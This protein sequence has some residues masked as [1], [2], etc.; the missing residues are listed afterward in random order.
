MKSIFISKSLSN[1][2]SKLICLTNST[3]MNNESKLGFFNNSNFVHLLFTFIIIF[4]AT[5]CSNN[6]CES[7]NTG[8]IIVENFNNVGTLHIFNN[9]EIRAINS[10]GDLVIEP[11][12]KQSTSLLAGDH[13]LR[14]ILRVTN[15]SGG[16]C[17]VS[18]TSLADRTT[19]LMACE[20]KNL[21]Y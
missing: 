8:N 1:N 15:C 19:T 21:V 17:S 18:N 6:E 5:S 14:A 10:T 12:E 7:D 16:R 4:T 11:G 3:A 13:I 9:K 20:D 2:Y